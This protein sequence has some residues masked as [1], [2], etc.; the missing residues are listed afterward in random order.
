MLHRCV[1]LGSKVT[2]HFYLILFR[3]NGQSTVIVFESSA[4]RAF[5]EGLK[6]ELHL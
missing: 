3:P 4:D 6:I 1:I 5:A 2:P